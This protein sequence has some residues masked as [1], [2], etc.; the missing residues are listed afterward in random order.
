MKT[1]QCNMRCV[2]RAARTV[3][4]THASASYR[5]V[6]RSSTH[7]AHTC[8]CKCTCTCACTC[9]HIHMQMRMTYYMSCEHG[10]CMCPIQASWPFCVLLP[11]CRDACEKR[12]TVRSAMRLGQ[13]AVTPSFWADTSL[14]STALLPLSMLVSAGARLRESVAAAPFV[15][16]CDHLKLQQC[17][18]PADSR[19]HAELA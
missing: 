19:T 16:P 5:V 3:R 9:V 10:M 1:A 6:V 2:L 17:T 14:L 4:S 8:T 11:D 15:A 12:T 7:D 13:L 18:A